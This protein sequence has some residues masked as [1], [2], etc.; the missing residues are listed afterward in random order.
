VALATIVATADEERDGRVRQ[1]T[2]EHP[3]EAAV[4]GSVPR[5]P[6]GG[7][8]GSPA[9]RRSFYLAFLD[10]Q[11]DLGR[12]ALATRLDRPFAPRAGYGLWVK[13][14]LLD[15]RGRVVSA[16][17]RA[18]PGGGL[19][20]TITLAPYL[21]AEQQVAWCTAW[22]TE[23][24]WQASLFASAALDWCLPGGLVASWEQTEAVGPCQLRTLRYAADFSCTATPPP[25]EPGACP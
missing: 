6:A 2:P 12:V 19:E 25:W 1:G 21:G 24:A 22:T 14:E 10:G 5:L 20:E 16:S 18:A 8:A 15:P 13:E 3:P 9:V 7:A 11:P 23:V 4:A 17:L